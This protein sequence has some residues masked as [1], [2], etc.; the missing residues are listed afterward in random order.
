M[1]EDTVKALGFDGYAA[2]WGGDPVYDKPP[3]QY[4]DGYLFYNFS[5]EGYDKKFL[6]K[7]IPAIDRCILWQ[8]QTGPDP[9]KNFTKREKAKNVKNLLLL[10]AECQ[11]RL[12]LK[13]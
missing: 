13:D 1:D 8:D 6:K 10:K 11:R 12:D 3:M 4:G 2:L 7:F 9:D 5:V